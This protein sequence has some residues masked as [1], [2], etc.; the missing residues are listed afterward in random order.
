MGQS[1]PLAATCLPVQ[2]RKLPPAPALLSIDVHGGA[3]V[4]ACL[5]KTPHCY[6]QPQFLLSGLPGIM[7]ELR[8][9]VGPERNPECPV[10]HPVLN[11]LAVS[12]PYAHCSQSRLICSI[13]GRALD[14]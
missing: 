3:S 9:R 5:S 8:P 6:K 13:S 14:E 10:C 7:Q 1:K 4:R 12:L 2:I 11:S